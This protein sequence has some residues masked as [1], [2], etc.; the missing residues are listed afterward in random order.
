MPADMR[1]AGKLSLSQK[2]VLPLVLALVVGLSLSTWLTVS[3]SGAVI[4][5]L[6]LQNGGNVARAEAE[7]VMND[8]SSAFEVARTLR[9]TIIS[10][11]KSGI[12][13]RN[14]YLDVI[15]Q[16]ALNHPH[17]TAVWTA[18]EPNAL[19]GRDADFIGKEGHDATG[20]FVPYIMHMPGGGLNLSPLK[21]YDKQGDGDYYLL[22][23]D[24]N[25]EQILE[26]YPYSIDGRVFLI[27][28]LSVPISIEG[29]VVAVVGVDF[30]LEALN[31]RLNSVKIFE[32]GT[33]SLISNKGLWVAYP[34][35]DDVGKSILTNTPNMQQA[36][37]KIAAGE[38][39]SFPDYSPAIKS[40]VIRAFEPIQPGNTGTPWSIMALLPKDKIEAPVYDV[41]WLTVAASLAL[42]IVLAMIIVM[43]IRKQAVKPVQ[44]MTSTVSRMADG[45]LDIDVSG[46]ERGDELGVMA[47]AI[48]VLKENLIKNKEMQA[49]EAIA[50]AER[51]QRAERIAELTAAFDRETSVVVET[52]TSAATEMQSTSASM[53]AM[54]EE[55]SDQATTAAA[56]SERTT[57]NVQTVAAAAE[58]LSASVS[59]IGRQVSESANLAK[60]AVNKVEQTNVTVGSLS[61][62]ANR[63]GSVIQLITDVASQT[64]LLALNATIEAARAGEAGKGFA[65]VASEVK[66]L[67]NQ[68]SKA[69]EEIGQQIN[70]M[71]NATTGAVDAISAIKDTIERLDS[72]SAAIAAAVEEQG[73]ATQEISRNIQQA[74]QG[75]QSV[76]GNIV[77][78]SQSADETGGAA[79]QMSAGSDELLQQINGM[80]IQVETFITDIRSA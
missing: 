30:S 28:S 63:I 15:H 75:T 67:A 19:D 62:A 37:S 23:R 14:V 21:D 41:I 12:A 80:R 3:R 66:N 56:A 71:Q 33:I 48:N 76:S 72:I 69:T 73:A 13:D 59:E 70:A 52:V 45:D 44:A 42:T 79:T 60:E 25:E 4:E 53:S 27:T 2:T 40:D 34:L 6:S 61:D 36:L 68:T 77:A 46:V 7:S 39:F 18:W 8:F 5:E 55:T 38:T 11:K 9:D 47:G 49:R 64:N 74:A 57:E 29:K 65:V 35:A 16:V 78:V 50:Q 43:Q 22:A 24:S 26:P 17:L 58:E 20:R 32:T 10:M 31:T 51:T 1:I 54:A